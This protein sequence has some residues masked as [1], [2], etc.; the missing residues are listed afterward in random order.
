[1]VFDEKGLHAIR[2]WSVVPSHVTVRFWVAWEALYCHA[3]EN[4][5]V[6]LHHMEEDFGS[7]FLLLVHLAVRAKQEERLDMT[8]L[9]PRKEQC[10]VVD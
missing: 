2:I 1:M 9:L 7:D 4:L 6:V 10:E 3:I 8:V 5:V